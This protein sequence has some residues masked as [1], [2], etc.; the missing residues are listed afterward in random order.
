[1]DLAVLIGGRLAGRLRLGSGEP[2][3]EYDPSYSRLGH[4]PLSAQFPLAARGASGEKLRWWLQGLLPDDVD[5]IRGL[6]REHNL[7][8][9]DDLML[10]GTPMG[11]DCAGAVQLCQLDQ[12]EVLLA[13]GGDQEPVTQPDIADWLRRIRTD[14]ARRAYR[15]EGADSGFSLTGI[16]PKVAVRQTSDG[17]WAVPKGA[18]P[19][20]HI[21]KATRS[22]VFPHEAVVEHLIMETA[23]QIGLVAARTAVDVYDGLEVL[24]VE[25]FDRTSDGT[26]RIH[27]EDMCQALGYHP[28]RKYQF[29]D[30]P[31]PEEISGLLRRADPSRA[32]A[33]IERFRD[34]LLYQWL[35][36]SIDGHAKNYSI[37]HPGSGTVVL[38]PLYDV[39]SWLPY[40][41]GEP[42]GLF[43]LAM[44]VGENY[45]IQ[46][47]DQPSAMRHTAERLGLD[48]SATAERAAELASAIPAA[49]GKAIGTLPPGTESL[50]CVDV[51]HTELSARAD[52]CGQIAEEAAGVA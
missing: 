1:M 42:I 37:M 15:T 41:K 4:P 47:A 46:S 49:L 43:R 2:Q 9:Q 33:N 40:R 25:R 3:F 29:E 24:I 6:R 22:D 17:A 51:L 28:D 35:A 16:Q 13:G 30:G 48:T 38:S 39:S 14:P 36:A 27:Q 19:T 12:A 32:E 8:A 20:T 34:G 21:I 50:A 10:L 45:R 31:S 26:A 11:A 18:V 44:R 52:R 23:G 5:T 7:H